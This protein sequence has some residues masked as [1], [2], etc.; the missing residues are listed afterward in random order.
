MLGIIF[1]GNALK[2]G[3]R[4]IPYTRYHEQIVLEGIVL[5][6]PY[7][8]KKIARLRCRIRGVFTRNGH[9]PVNEDIILTIYRYNLM[10]ESGDR[11]RFLCKLKEIKNFCN[12]GAFDYRAFMK[13]K[14]IACKAY[15]KDGRYVVFMGKQ[16]LPFPYNITEALRS[17]IRN[18]FKKELQPNSFGIFSAIILGERKNLDNSTK[19]MINRAGLG[20]ILAV[21]GLHI[22]LVAWLSF[23]FIKWL[24][25]RS[26]R[27]GLA[28]DVKKLSA[29]CTIVPVI[30]YCL[31]SGFRIPTQRAMIMI[32]VFLFSVILEKQDDIPSSLCLAGLII[33]SIFPLSI[34]SASFQLSFVAVAGIIWLMPYIKGYILGFII[35]THDQLPKGIMSK[36]LFYFLDLISVS[37]SA[38]IVLLPLILYYFHRIPLLSIPA[39]VSTIPILGL[40]VL[41]TGLFSISLLPVSYKL[42]TLFLKI[43]N[44]GMEQMLSI[45]RLWASMPCSSI[46]F[47]QPNI[48]EIGLYYGLLFLITKRNHRIARLGILAICLIILLD[49]I[50]WVNRIKFNKDLRITF[51]DVGRGGCALIEFPMGK[52]MLIDGGGSSPNFNEARMVIAP[53]L[54]YSRI[55]KI[56]YI[57]LLH[58]EGR[59]MNRLSFIARIFGAKKLR[60]LNANINGVTI[61]G[62]N[63]KD[64]PLEIGYK[65]ISIIFVKD[66][67]GYKQAYKGKVHD[68]ENSVLVF[69]PCGIG[70]IRYNENTR[71]KPKICIVLG[72]KGKKLD[73]L[74]SCLKRSGCKVYSTYK[75]GAIRMEIKERDEIKVKEMRGICHEGI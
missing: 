31:I 2:R 61:S 7:V 52:K 23:I 18:F 49:T 63:N 30:G 11:I 32:L 45:I 15:V 54:W 47:F 37:I 59:H 67:Q 70:N 65:G 14:G 25:L 16:D 17:P 56:D 44:F 43:S 38:L 66:L 29:I 24:M 8:N 58:P 13:R 62:S 46:W 20:H 51:L 64:I 9:N 48:L 53:F 19:E 60:E 68:P 28:F 3:S 40:W 72:S 12:P 42:A 21:S 10:L 55:L 74:F 73:L 39:N 26:Y 33:L 50:F 22:G 69:L 71:N 5:E 41:P 34:F 6:P 27:L 75:N 1:G 35:P 4:L 57:L 36:F